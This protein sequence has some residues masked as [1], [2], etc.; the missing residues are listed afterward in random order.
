MSKLKGAY[1]SCNY[2]SNE[3]IERRSRQE[4]E[5][6]S[7]GLFRYHNR[8][9]ISRPARALINAIFI[10]YHDNDGYPNYRRLMTLLLKRYWW[11]KMT[12][13]CMTYCQ[14]CV[15]C[16]R[17]KPDRRG[18]ASLQPLGIPEYPWEIIRIDYFIDLPKRG[19]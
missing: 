13:D 5:K 19:T 7:D 12:F 3:N 11:G 6:A 17:A 4:I 1:S 9:V 16:N 18:G 15:V 10:E 8:V 14:H 2:F